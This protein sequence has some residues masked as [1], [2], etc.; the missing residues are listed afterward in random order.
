MAR[1]AL[2]PMGH[3]GLN[4]CNRDADARSRRNDLGEEVTALLGGEWGKLGYWRGSYPDYEG[5]RL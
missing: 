4:H 5:L 1:G 2:G 3:G